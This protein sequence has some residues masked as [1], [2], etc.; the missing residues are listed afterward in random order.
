MLRVW[1]ALL[2]DPK[3]FM[4]VQC[5]ATAMVQSKEEELMKKDFAE[6]V[7]LL[8]NYEV[9]DVDTLLQRMNQ[10]RM[11]ELQRR[12]GTLRLSELPG[13]VW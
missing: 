3:R 6:C 5:L 9:T 13:G 12:S 10:I 4:L 7:Q 11:K 2:A 8:Q 1:D